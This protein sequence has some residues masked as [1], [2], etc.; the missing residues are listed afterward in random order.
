MKALQGKGPGG[1]ALPGGR[2]PLKGKYI[3]AYMRT[4]I[5]AYIRTMHTSIYPYVWR[6]GERK[7]KER[8]GKN[9]ANLL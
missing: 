9:Q 4:S 2:T 6:G 3:Q 5:Q 1:Q 8:K 7:G